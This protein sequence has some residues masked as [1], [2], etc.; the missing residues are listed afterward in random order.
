MAEQASVL[1]ARELASL[2]DLAEALTAEHGALLGNDPDALDAALVRKNACI[3]QQHIA[4]SA[5]EALLPGNL[6][7]HD[8]NE[9]QR[10][11]VAQLHTL[12]QQCQHHNVSNGALIAR[13]QQ[14]M[15]TA[16]D[17]LRHQEP[18]PATY[19]GSGDTRE[20][21]NSRSLGSA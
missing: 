20:D 2:E 7:D 19:S 15:R 6:S 5:R 9:E 1:L 8:L 12:S 21:H 13:K 17:T 11:I 16:L 18:V 3:E 14:V 10:D 4:T